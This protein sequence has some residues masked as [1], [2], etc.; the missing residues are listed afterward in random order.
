[1]LCQNLQYLKFAAAFRT[2]KPF[3]YRIIGLQR[4]TPCWHAAAKAISMKGFCLIFAMGS[5]KIPTPDKTKAAIPV[6]L[7]LINGVV[8]PLGLKSP[9]DFTG[10]TFSHP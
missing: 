8:S 7:R 1:M 10:I 2:V 4:Y 6:E 3:H 5:H 9:K